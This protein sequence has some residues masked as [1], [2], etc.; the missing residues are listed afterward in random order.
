MTV[1]ARVAPASVSRMRTERRS[2]SSRT[3]STR[4]LASI[5]SIRLVIAPEVTMAAGIS[6]PAVSAYGGP[7]GAG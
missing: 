4:P 3:R 7:T 2:A 5:R 6:A 1:S